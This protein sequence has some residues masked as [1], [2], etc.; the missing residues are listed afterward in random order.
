MVEAP[1]GFQCVECVRDQ[2]RDLK[3]GRTIS[4]GAIHRDPMLITKILVAINVIVFGLQQV[5]T[6][7]VDQRFQMVGGC[8]AFYDQWWRLI[9]AAFLHESVV[10][11]GLN[12]LALW[13]VG[14]VVEPR[15]G[16][17]RFLIVYLLSALAGS[18]LSYAANPALYASVGASGAIFGLFGALFVLFLRLRMEIGG[19]V[20][21]IVINLA[22]GFIPGMNIDW[23][24]HLGG[25]IMGTIV[26]AAM[27]YAP[28]SQRLLITIAV[29]IAAFVLCV[30]AVG[31]RTNQLNQ[32]GH[33]FPK[34]F[35]QVSASAELPS[36]TGVAPGAD[37][38]RT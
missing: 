10:H 12:M 36:S 37:V 21:L 33:H 32:G 13:V 38:P 35:C 23:H 14:N 27:V 24:A 11:I 26:T 20:A 1:V 18:A 28:Q 7:Q 9:T 16:R 22:L 8:V 6:L 5:S 19:I 2:N 25:L 17:W 30:V 3:Q 4:G 29:S 31:W 34:Y 15:L